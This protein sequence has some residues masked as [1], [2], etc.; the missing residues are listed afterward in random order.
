MFRPP[1]RSALCRP[2]SLRRWVTRFG[3]VR[4]PVPV[5]ACTGGPFR[6]Y[7][8]YCW[9]RGTKTWLLPVYAH[10]SEWERA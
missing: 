3:R 5:A 9:K 4:L 8:V 7:F 10:A 6:Y 1:V 2:L